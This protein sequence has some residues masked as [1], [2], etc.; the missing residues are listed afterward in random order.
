MA[1]HVSVHGKEYLLPKHHFMMH[2]PGQLLRHRRMLDCFV[3]ERKGKSFKG[4]LD[5]SGSGHSGLEKSILRR[6]LYDQVDDRY[7]PWTSTLLEP[8]RRSD[9]GTVS[10]KMYWVSMH[11]E[12]VQ[13]GDIRVQGDHV[14]LVEACIERDGSFFLLAK[15]GR[16]VKRLAYMDVWTKPQDQKLVRLQRPL[17][18][19]LAWK[20]QGSQLLTLDYHRGK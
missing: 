20:L 3:T 6:A 2:V 12:L 8:Y 4:L 5:A 19:C 9:A 10:M 17:H 11:R 13:A 1:S 18:Q 7:L 14:Y 16:F 15:E